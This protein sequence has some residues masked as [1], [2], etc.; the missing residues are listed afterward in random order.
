MRWPEGPPHLTLNLF[1][2]LFGFLC[3]F[4]NVG[5]VFVLVG[6]GL[7]FY[8]LVVVLI[9]LFRVFVFLSYVFFSF[10]FVFVVVVVVSL[11]LLSDYEQNTVFPLG[12]VSKW[13]H[14]LHCYTSCHLRF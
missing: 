1:F 8:V 13:L 2:L 14:F 12:L 3:F 9:V 10:C 4:F 11:V 7:L 5:Y 6:F